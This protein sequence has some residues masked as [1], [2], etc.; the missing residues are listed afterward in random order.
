MVRTVLAE[1][2]GLAK[3]DNRVK[4]DIRRDVSSKG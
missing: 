1:A 2:L 4:V 3:D